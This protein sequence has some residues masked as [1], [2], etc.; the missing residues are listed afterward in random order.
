MISPLNIMISPIWKPPLFYDEPSKNDDLSTKLDCDNLSLLLKIEKIIDWK[1]KKKLRKTVNINVCQNW[2]LLVASDSMLCVQIWDEEL[3]RIAQRHADQCKFAHDC[4]SCRKTS[5]W[6]NSQG[7]S[8]SGRSH[9]QSS[10]QLDTGL[11]LCRL[12]T[13]W[14]KKRRVIIM[15]AVLCHPPALTPGASC[16]LSGWRLEV[17]WWK[18]VIFSLIFMQ[19]TGS[20]R[21]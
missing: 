10:Q 17:T 16:T 15:Y 18:D 12:V 4:A 6:G 11:Q 8:D 5:R 20:H 7:C 3:A 2:R 14:T 9:P 21:G 19:D 13:S 1:T